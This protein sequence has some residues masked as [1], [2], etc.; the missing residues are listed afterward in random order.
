MRKRVA[1]DSLVQALEH[2]RLL[3]RW[4]RKSMEET[5]VI[6]HEVGAVKLKQ[7]KTLGTENVVDLSWWR[8]CAAV[9][10]LS[11]RGEKVSLPPDRPVVEASTNVVNILVVSEENEVEKFWNHEPILKCVLVAC[12]PQASYVHFEWG[13]RELIE[14]TILF[15]AALEAWI[16]AFEQWIAEQDTRGEYRQKYTRINLEQM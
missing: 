16:V 3:S 13:W 4:S 12:I 5:E 1:R 15:L 11:C 7:L 14:G 8:Q 2:H 6:K 10:T 9:S